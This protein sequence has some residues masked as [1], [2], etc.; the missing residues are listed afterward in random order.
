[1]WHVSSSPDVDTCVLGCVP[2]WRPTPPSAALH[3]TEA[4]PAGSLC[5]PPS[6]FTNTQSVLHHNRHLGPARRRGSSQDYVLQRTFNFAS[7]IISQTAIK[8]EPH[9]AA[10]HTNTNGSE[11]ETRDINVSSQVSRYT[12]HTPFCL[13]LPSHCPLPQP[14]RRSPLNTVRSPGAFLPVDEAT[15]QP[16]CTRL[17]AATA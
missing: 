10:Q 5:R 11:C 9:D 16:Q 7:L 3:Q 13:A 1:M 14:W 17:C 4:R 15:H 8:G 12:F 2:A 6:G